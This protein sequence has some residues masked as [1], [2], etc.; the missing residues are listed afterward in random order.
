RGDDEVA[1]EGEVLSTSLRRRGRLQIVTARVSDGTATIPA[2][3]FNQPWLAEQLKS[4]VHVRLRGRLRRY[5]F[6]VRSYDRGKAERTA[7]FAPVYPASEELTAGRVR[8]LVAGALAYAGDFPD[9]LPADLKTR[10]RLPLRADAF[11]SLHRPASLGEA[12]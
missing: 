7:D 10:E 6:D 12:E 8:G 9:P 3:W 5:G 2:T 1:I 4:R 11:V